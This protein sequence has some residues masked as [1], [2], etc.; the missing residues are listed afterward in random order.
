MGMAKKWPQNALLTEMDG[1]S[2]D[3]KRP[4]FVLAA[5]NFDVEEGQGGMGTID[6]ALARRFD[7][8]VLVDLPNKDDRYRYIQMILK[9]NKTHKV[10]EQMIERLCRAIYRHEPCQHGVGAG[11]GQPHGGQAKYTP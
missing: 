9:K 4:V 3:P 2:V 10:S 6:A 8:K 1:F 7:R 5:T 11:T